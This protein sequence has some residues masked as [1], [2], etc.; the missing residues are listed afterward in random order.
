MIKQIKEVMDGPK[1]Y[2]ARELYRQFKLA[3]TDGERRFLREE[4]KIH[5]TRKHHEKKL[6]NK[7]G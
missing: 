1:D 4:L 2:I 3:K 6:A 7:N 5:F